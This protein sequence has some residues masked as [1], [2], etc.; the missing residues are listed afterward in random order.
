MRKLCGHDARFFDKRQTLKFTP[1]ADVKPR[2]LAADLN[3]RFTSGCG[4]GSEGSPT[5]GWAQTTVAYRPTPFIDVSE[6]AASKRTWLS[7]L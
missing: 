4:H 7:R 3:F 1:Q 2:A 5:A 6:M